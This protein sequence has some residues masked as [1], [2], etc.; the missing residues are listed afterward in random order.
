LGLRLA[1]CSQ[2]SGYEQLEGTIPRRRQDTETAREL[3]PYF[4]YDRAKREFGIEGHAG[5]PE[6]L[7]RATVEM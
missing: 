1:G 4:M 5:A 2:P 7:A 6:D 3:K